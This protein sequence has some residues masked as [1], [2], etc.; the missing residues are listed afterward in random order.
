[1]SLKSWA[2]EFYFKSA[3]EIAREV[4]IDL[5]S[6]VP[7]P[8]EDLALVNHALLKWQGLLPH[9]L[10]KHNVSL[11]SYNTL[12]GEETEGSIEITSTTC[13]LC[14]VYYNEDD[15]RDLCCGCPLY[16]FLTQ[17]CFGGEEEEAPYNH[18]IYKHDPQPMI[19]ALIGTKKM[20]LVQI[21]TLIKER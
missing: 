8:A 4:N 2:E 14:R 13:S 9:N 11:S 16:T 19:E 20:L 6:E 3:I 1:M 15:Y 7:H 12:Q 21:Q 17:P 5:D 18:F 10:E